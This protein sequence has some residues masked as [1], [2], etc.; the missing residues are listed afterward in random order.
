MAGEVPAQFVV[1]RLPTPERCGRAGQA[2]R[3]PKHMQQTVWVECQKKASVG[4]KC[5]EHRTRT[6]SYRL[7]VE[8]LHCEAYSMVN[9]FICR[10]RMRRSRQ[11][12]RD[13]SARRQRDEITARKW[14]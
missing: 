7:Q 1:W 11:Q 10:H 4:L 3:D 8:R 9:D 12:R 2:R 14:P 5:V 13:C 6:Q